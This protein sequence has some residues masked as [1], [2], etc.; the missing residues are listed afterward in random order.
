MH[1]I[2]V[3]HEADSDGVQK[4]ELKDHLPKETQQSLR[5]RFIVLADGRGR[6]AQPMLEKLRRI[7]NERLAAQVMHLVSNQQ[8]VAVKGLDRSQELRRTQRRMGNHHHLNFRTTQL[9]PSGKLA[10]L[11]VALLFAPQGREVLGF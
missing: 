1:E 5:P 9:Q 6:Q 4:G 10:Q 2:V 3:F 8:P 7:K 11:L